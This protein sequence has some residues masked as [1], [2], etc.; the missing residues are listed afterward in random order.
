MSNE[1][2]SDMN[3]IRES[4]SIRIPNGYVTVIVSGDFAQLIPEIAKDSPVWAADTASSRAATQAFRELQG[5][6]RQ[7][8]SLYRSAD[9]SNLLLNLAAAFPLIELHHGE[10]STAPPYSGIV[11]IGLE[12]TVEIESMILQAGLFMKPEDLA[13]FTLPVAA[14]FSAHRK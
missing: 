8:V 14:W 11:V 7:T 2:S 10:Y 9:Q 4:R 12:P 1:R 3:G 13:L 6:E 5:L